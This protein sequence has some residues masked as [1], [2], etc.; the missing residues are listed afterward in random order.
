V[1][2]M[3]NSGDR[4]FSMPLEKL[5]QDE[6]PIVAEHAAWAAKKLLALSP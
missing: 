6:D 4:R 3:G 2:A 5:S 1:V